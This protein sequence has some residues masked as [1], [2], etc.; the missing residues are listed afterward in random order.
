QAGPASAYA[1]K[2][3]I[4]AEAE[5]LRDRILA[6]TGSL[7]ARLFGPPVDIQEDDA[8][9]VIV[10]DQSRRSLYVKMRRSQPVAI[11][12]TFDAPVME[13]NCESRTVSTVATQ[14]LMLMNS[15][16]VLDQAK[17]LAERAAREAVQPPAEMLAS[18]PEIPP[19]PSS[20][21]QSGYGSFDEQSQRTG[22]VAV[23]PHWT[24]SAWQGGPE[25][26]AA[27][28][29]WGTLNASGGHPGNTH[30]FGPIRRWIA[31]ADGTVTV[32]GSLQH[33]NENGNGV[34]GLIVSAQKGVLGDWTAHNSRA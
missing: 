4:R 26:P 23:L 31:P 2:P 15:D 17:K 13:T 6:V 18:L 19:P 8:G 12:Q 29:A 16:F 7:D 5:L 1:C 3:L 33:G 28:P 27:R 21:W 24:G 22:S 14:A 20:A 25:L 30:E 34:R 10:A 11:L 32:S 9:Q